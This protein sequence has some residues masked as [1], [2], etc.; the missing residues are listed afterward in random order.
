MKTKIFQYSRYFLNLHPSI[1]KNRLIFRVYIGTNYFINIFSLLKISFD[2]YL[3]VSYSIINPLTFSC[4]FQFILEYQILHIYLLNKHFFYIFIYKNSKRE[5]RFI[6]FF[7]IPPNFLL[8]IVLLVTIN[9]FYLQIKF[10]K[11]FC[12]NPN[13]F[14]FSN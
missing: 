13:F 9:N 14:N 1:F 12:S 6:F 8:K 2:F 10:F 4:E 3:S 7:N 5:N 11:S